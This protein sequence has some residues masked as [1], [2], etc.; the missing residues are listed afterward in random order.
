MAGM[1]ETSFERTA[2][3]FLGKRKRLDP[4]AQVSAEAQGASP[5]LWGAIRL[6]SLKVT[7]IDGISAL[8]VGFARLRAATSD[9]GVYHKMG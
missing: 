5:A 9:K 1:P 7:A 6:N 2:F 8:K 3:S 4:L